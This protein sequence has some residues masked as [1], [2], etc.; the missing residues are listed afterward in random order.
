MSG[1]EVEELMAALRAW[2][3]QAKHG[4]QKDLAERLGVSPQKLNHW[5]T[6]RALPN[7][8]D[9]LRLHAFLKRHRYKRTPG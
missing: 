1:D 5:I 8:R 7:L 6:G 2:A 3:A 9:G 4:E